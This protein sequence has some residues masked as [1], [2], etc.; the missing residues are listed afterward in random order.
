MNEVYRSPGKEV[1]MLSLLVRRKADTLPTQQEATRDNITRM[2]KWL[3]GYLYEHRE[4]D[5]FQYHIE[6]EFSVRRSTVS[7][8]V[9]L[10][11]RHGLIERQS[12]PRD[13]RLK[14]L[15]LTPKAL[16]MHEK[17]RGELRSLDEKMVVGLT[18]QQLDTFYEVLDHIRKNLE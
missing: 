11:E 13:A 2:Q 9:K 17:F 1:H 14:K 6:R 8:V 15:V 3:I 16:Q 10:M 4:E 7:E 12:I 18:A 5:I